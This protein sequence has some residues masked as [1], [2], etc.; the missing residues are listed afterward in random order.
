[1][2]PDFPGKNIDLRWLARCAG[3]FSLWGWFS[4]VGLKVVSPRCAVGRSPS[5]LIYFS[6]VV[7]HAFA[8]LRRLAPSR[9]FFRISW[10]RLDAGDEPLYSE[11]K[12]GLHDGALEITPSNLVYFSWV[13]AYAFA[14]LRRLAPT[15]FF[16]GYLGR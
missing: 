8:P 7:A 13:F 5:N 12:S 10:T 6:W 14:P 3:L 15:C 11:I 9:F 2:N 16:S 4:S 1:M